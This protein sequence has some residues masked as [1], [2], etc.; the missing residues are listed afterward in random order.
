MSRLLFLL[1]ILVVVAIVSPNRA[2][3]EPR[4]GWDNVVVTM[5][6]YHDIQELETGDIYRASIWEGSVSG[7]KWAQFGRCLT[8]TCS[9]VASN[10]LG[11]D[12]GIYAAGDEFE[13]VK[14]Y[15]TYDDQ[16]TLLG[17]SLFY[18]SD[19]FRLK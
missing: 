14:F 5:N 3:A 4:G 9:W 7:Q 1:T 16:G 13:G 12:G 10:L 15:M 2:Q 17:G 18:D 11:N 19:R 8:E 6:G